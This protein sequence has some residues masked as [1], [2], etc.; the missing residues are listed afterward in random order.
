MSDPEI[1]NVDDDYSDYS[2]EPTS[3]AQAEMPVVTETRDKCRNC[4]CKR[5]EGGEWYDDEYC[6]GKCKKADGGRIPPAPQRVKEAG[7]KASLADYLLD[8]PKRLGEKDRHGQRIKGRIP[9][10]YRRRYE[11]ERLNWGEPLSRDELEQAG[12][13]AN[14]V[15]IPGDFDYTP[16]VAE[17]GQDN[18]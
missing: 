18:D 8:Y 15:P 11:P 6:S 2:D 5:G 12:F 9:K 13:R 16:E 10:I 4:G 17:R 7:K 3:V 14:R 1:S